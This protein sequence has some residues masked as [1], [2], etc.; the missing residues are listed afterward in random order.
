MQARTIASPRLSR[1]K[2]STY[3]PVLA[4]RSILVRLCMHR[5]MIGV[6]RGG[7]L[8][9]GGLSAARTV[10]FA[11][12]EASIQASCMRHDSRQRVRELLAER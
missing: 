9:S 7:W 12:G 8:V 5:A 1:L 6:E 2:D 11:R 3:G 4:E 10:A